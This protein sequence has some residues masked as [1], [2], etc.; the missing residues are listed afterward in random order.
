MSRAQRSACLQRTSGEATISAEHR[1]VQPGPPGARGGLDRQGAAASRGA[2]EERSGGVAPSAC[3]RASAASESGAVRQR[4]P[5]PSAGLP[6]RREGD[7]PFLYTGEILE[8]VIY[9]N[10]LQK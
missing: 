10:T 5:V 6:D 1:P 2:P 3:G 9:N 7:V 4:P 8:I